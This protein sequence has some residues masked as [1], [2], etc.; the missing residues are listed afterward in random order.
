MSKDV[1][2]NASMVDYFHQEADLYK[3][4]KGGSVLV[5][6]MEISWKEDTNCYCVI[7]R[8]GLLHGAMQEDCYPITEGKNI[9]KA[10]ETTPLAQAKVMYSSIYNKQRD[11]GYVDMSSTGYNP[12]QMLEVLTLHRGKDASGELKPMLAYKTI[13]YI[14]FPCY[15][16]RKYDGI[17]N[18]VG[19]KFDGALHMTSRNGKE[20]VHLKHILKDLENVLKPTEILD[21]ELYS[22]EMNFQQIISAVKREQPQNKNIRLRAYDVAN[23]HPQDRRL[24]RLKRICKLAGPSIEYCPTHLVNNIEGNNCYII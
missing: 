9:G 19:F 16:Q 5:F 2:P 23:E 15:A 18:F 13:K 22:H 24:R 6:H 21:G 12:D 17:R 14:K 8:K 4:N 11:K 20:F 10:N 1:Y 7:T 3:L